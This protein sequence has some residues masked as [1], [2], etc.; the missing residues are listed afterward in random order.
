MAAEE[1]LERALDLD[2]RPFL[3]GRRRLAMEWRLFLA[4]NGL[5]PAAAPQEAAVEEAVPA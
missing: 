4:R 2:Y 5:T 3:A 1:I